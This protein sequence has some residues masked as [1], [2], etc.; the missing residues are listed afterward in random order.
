MHKQA[1][2][3][4]LVH[5]NELMQI[6]NANR[7]HIVVRRTDNPSR[8]VEKRRG[9]ENR[10]HLALSAE[11]NLRRKMTLLTSDAELVQESFPNLLVD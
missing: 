7:R 11:M 8:M 5:R 2:T 6:K 9:A 1:E 10:S 4:I 3:K